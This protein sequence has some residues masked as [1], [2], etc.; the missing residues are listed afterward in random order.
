MFMHACAGVLA[1]PQIVSYC[2]LPGSPAKSTV[3]LHASLHSG[4]EPSKLFPK[5]YDDDLYLQR[6]DACIGGLRRGSGDASQPKKTRHIV[7]GLTE[8]KRHRPLN[9]G[10]DNGEKLFLGN[11]ESGG[12]GNSSVSSSPRTWP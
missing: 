4:I 11:R 10:R 6:T 1:C 3:K 5:D 8:A 7:I 9:A 12:V 2:S